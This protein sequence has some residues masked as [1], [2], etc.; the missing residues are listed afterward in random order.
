MH[1]W[2]LVH[3]RGRPRH[4]VRRVP[5]RLP[6]ALPVLPQPRHLVHA[7]RPRRVTVD[8]LVGRDRAA[9]GGSSS[10]AG[11]GVTAQRRRAAAA[12]RLHRAVFRHCAKELGLHTALDTSGFLGDRADRRA[13]RRHRPGAARHQV[14]TRTTYRRVDRPG[15]AARRWGS[16]AG[17]PTAAR[18]CGSGSCSCPGLTDA[19]ENVEAVAR[20]PLRC[21]RWAPAARCSGSRCCRSTSWARQVARA[22][23]D[24]STGRHPPARPRAGR[25]RA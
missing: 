6:A 8:E 14:R 15:A 25:A 20:T 2:D 23:R 12:A 11:G 17:W 16:P 9:T 10:V 3:R 13:A 19:V 21:R 4:P 5:R 24:L 22:G 18:R 7:R 1:S